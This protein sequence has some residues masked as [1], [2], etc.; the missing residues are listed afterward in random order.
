MLYELMTC[1]GD[2]MTFGARCRAGY[3]EY[4]AQQ[5]RRNVPSKW[6]VRNESVCGDSTLM[7]LRRMDQH[8]S[9]HESSRTVSVMIGTNDSKPDFR[10]PPDLFEELY[11]QVMDR[12]LSKKDVTVFCMMI[13]KV[14][15]PAL[16]PYDNVCNELIFEYNKRIPVIA[17][18]YGAVFVNLSELND[19]HFSD[20]VHF[21]DEGSLLTAKI[22][23]K[24]IRERMK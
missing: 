17:E 19:A 22:L 4:L 2:S 18:D 23:Y 9:A 14:Q 13:P 8:Y 7:L 24:A 3:P 5:M 6:V 16:M 11:R 1:Y 20:G 21:N 10:T 15:D 12:F